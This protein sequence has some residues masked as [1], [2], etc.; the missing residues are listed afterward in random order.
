MIISAVID[1][2][3]CNIQWKYNHIV[4]EQKIGLWALVAQEISQRRMD[5][6]Y[7]PCSGYQREK[8]QC[9]CKFAKLF[10]HCVY[11]IKVFNARVRP[12]IGNVFENA[13]T[14]VF[15]LFFSFVQWRQPLLLM[16]SQ[17]LSCLFT[18]SLNIYIS[19]PNIRFLTQLQFHAF[20]MYVT[21]E[22]INGNRKK[23]RRKKS[24][25]NLELLLNTVLKCIQ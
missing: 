5:F 10:L 12:A 25:R 23:K 17:S 1:K 9:I 22:I 15:P 6:G 11:K 24:F 20:S 14:L 21:E 13:Q 16:F 18:T 2:C 3:K 4:C 8:P 19:P 7:L